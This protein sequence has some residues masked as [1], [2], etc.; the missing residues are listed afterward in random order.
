[1]LS[2]QEICDGLR[3]NGEKAIALNWHAIDEKPVAGAEV[4]VRHKNG[5]S[6]VRWTGLAFKTKW[7]KTLESVRRWAYAPGEPARTLASR[8]FA[9]SEKQK[10]LEV[11][12]G[13]R[14]VLK[15][16]DRAAY[17]RTAAGM[18]WGEK[19]KAYCE[20]MADAYDGRIEQ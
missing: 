2:A 18:C 8:R 13:A 16:A 17:F 6:A 20:R 15:N 14:V 1:M 11:R 9:A 10:E 7:N 5:W 3:V 12:T 19:T 4:I